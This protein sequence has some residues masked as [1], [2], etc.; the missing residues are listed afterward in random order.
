MDLREQVFHAL[1]WTFAARILAQVITWA[2]TLIVIRLLSPADYG[3][4]AM[5]QI[6]IGLMISLTTSGVVDGLIRA[7][8]LTDRIVGQLTGLLVI[9]STAFFLIQFLGA[10]LIS[11]FFAEPQL[12]PIGRV[13]ALML[14]MLP[15]IV[16]TEALLTRNMQFRAKSL[17]DLGTTV[18]G[19]ALSLAMA[20]AGAAVWA[21]VTATVTVYLL[22]AIGLMILCPLPHRPV[23]NFTGVGDY[24]AFGTLVTLMG[25]VWTLCVSVDTMIGGYFLSA[26][27]LGLYA[28]ALQLAALPL[29]KVMPLINQVAYPAYALMQDQEERLQRHFLTAIRLAAAVSFPLFFGLASV[30]PELVTLLF[31]P[32]WTAMTMPMMVLALSMPLRALTYAFSPMLKAIGRPDLELRINLLTLVLLTLAFWFGVRWGELGLA[33]AWLAVTPLVFVFFLVR[34]C[35]AL[36][37]SH[38]AIVHDLWPPALAAGLMLAANRQIAARL[39]LAAVN[40]WLILALLVASGVVLYLAIVWIGLPAFRD[41]VL[42]DLRKLRGDRPALS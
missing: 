12:V 41:R 2:S 24:I 23:F 26:E 19:A 16:V 22:R 37:V 4:M 33:A 36:A 31:G 5:A 21:L 27:R 40:P 35:Q 34:G 1:R 30:A 14:L 11:R 3:I 15:W 8:H 20:I 38:G 28:T 25:I 32:Q 18:A 39:E 10:P 29:Y 6:S 9:M 13:L 42:A 7:K 17:I